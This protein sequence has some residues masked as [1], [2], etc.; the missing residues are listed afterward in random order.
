M[1]NARLLGR[2]SASG[3]AVLA[4]LSGF[5]PFL[6]NAQPQPTGGNATDAAKAPSPVFQM[7]YAS[8]GTM[9][10]GLVLAGWDDGLII[11]ALN[12]GSA[13]KDLQVGRITPAQIQHVISELDSAHFFDEQR[14]PAMPPDNSCMRM[15]ATRGGRMVEHRWNEA[16]TRPWGA[17]VGA[18]RKFYEFAK[19][20]AL[21]RTALIFASPTDYKPLDTDRGARGRFDAAV[22]SRA[23]PATIDGWGR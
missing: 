2:L 20:W 3:L 4:V 19:M 12:P 7:S 18:D 21:S 13:G 16:L 15:M 9:P 10:S 23:I 17:H 14:E 1:S 8:F 11:F 22:K 5:G 6:R